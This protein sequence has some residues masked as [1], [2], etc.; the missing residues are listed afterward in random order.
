MVLGNRFVCFGG[1]NRLQLFKLR[2]MAVY[3][4]AADT[5]HQ[6]FAKGDAPISLTQQQA[7]PL[8]LEESRYAPRPCTH[9]H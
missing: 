1:G 8:D 3:D 2:I 4:T 6:A 5:W 9:A 7:A